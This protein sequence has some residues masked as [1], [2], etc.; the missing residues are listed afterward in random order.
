MVVN[1]TE[2]EYKKIAI[3]GLKKVIEK[4]ENGEVKPQNMSSYRTATRSYL[5]MPEQRIPKGMCWTFEFDFI[6]D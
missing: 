2:Y 6:G 1:V 5:R 3:E 4:I